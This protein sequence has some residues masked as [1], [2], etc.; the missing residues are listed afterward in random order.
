[1]SSISNAVEALGGV[2]VDDS[3]ILGLRSLDGRSQFNILKGDD[4]SWDSDPFVAAYRVD[5]EWLAFIENPSDG[6]R[7]DCGGIARLPPTAIPLDSS[8]TFD[9]ILVVFR[10]FN[11][12]RQDSYG[13]DRLIYAT[14]EHFEGCILIV[15][16]QNYNDWYPSFVHSWS[17]D[18]SLPV[19]AP[20]TDY[21]DG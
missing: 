7:S 3:T 12:A 16:T 8:A 4:S 19:P 17:P 15:G 2:M 13:V 21:S 18:G 11:G 6:C 20:A 10:E 9:P 1:M 14:A 5:G